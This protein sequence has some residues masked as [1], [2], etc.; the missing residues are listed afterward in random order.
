MMVLRWVAAS[1]SEVAFRKLRGYKSM[2]KLV[3]ALRTHDAALGV[4][5]KLDDKA[6]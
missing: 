1:L 5:L 4:T 6:A 2:R 3:A